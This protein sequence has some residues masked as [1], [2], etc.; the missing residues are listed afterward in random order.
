[1]F[2]IYI[3]IK[4]NILS[5]WRRS[6]SWCG[7]SKAFVDLIIACITPHIIASISPKMQCRDYLHLI[8]TFSFHVK[9]VIGGILKIFWFS[10]FGYILCRPSQAANTCMV[11][12][13]L[14]LVRLTHLLSKH[15][16]LATHML[17]SL[18]FDW[19]APPYDTWMCMVFEC[20]LLLGLS[21]V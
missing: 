11:A 12:W 17:A 5:N 8:S 20:N 7:L 14:E 2:H 18:F 3:F 16:D 19:K 15:V 21:Y 4:Y 6:H 13:D 10:T 1:M 9:I